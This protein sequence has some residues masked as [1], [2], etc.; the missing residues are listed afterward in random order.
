MKRALVLLSVA[1]ALAVVAGCSPTGAFCQ[2]QSDCDAFA[3]QFPLGL[4]QVGESDDSVGVCI[5][6]NDGF[7]RELRAN[8]ESQCQDW[9]DAWE[10]YMACV[11]Q[12]YGGDP[13]KACDPLL[14]G[15]DNPCHSELRDVD[16]AIQDA[17]NRCSPDET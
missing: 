13:D 10:A 12:E 1:A 4:D 6:D 8:E 7:L 2:A 17:G 3:A 15:S 14:R 16:N 5:A 9:A 11:A